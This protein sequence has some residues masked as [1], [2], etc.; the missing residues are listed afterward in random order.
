VND[1]DAIYSKPPLQIVT[2]LLPLRT[3]ARPV[4]IEDDI[5]V[6]EPERRWRGWNHDDS[7]L[8]PAG[9]FNEAPH[10]QVG[11]TTPVDDESAIRRPG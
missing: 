6:P 4:R 8:A 1:L 7:G 2:V 11:C 3:V 9:E 10:N 5:V